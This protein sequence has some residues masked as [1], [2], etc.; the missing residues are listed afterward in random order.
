MYIYIYD[1]SFYMSKIKSYIS[2][3]DLVFIKLF[4]QTSLPPSLQSVP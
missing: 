3:Y 2:F 4:L 1:G